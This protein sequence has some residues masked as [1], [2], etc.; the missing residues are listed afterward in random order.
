VANLQFLG[1]EPPGIV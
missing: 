1:V